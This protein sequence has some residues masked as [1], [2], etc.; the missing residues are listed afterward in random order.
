MLVC[1]H[2][3]LLTSIM[4]QSLYVILVFWTF[5]SYS[6]NPLFVKELYFL[7]AVTL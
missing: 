5:Q 7:C 6:M 4:K 2:L 3:I 1:F